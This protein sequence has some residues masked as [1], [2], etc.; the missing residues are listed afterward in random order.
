MGLAL[1]CSCNFSTMK[2]TSYDRLRV[3]VHSD[4]AAMGRAAALFAQR[5]I[6][7]AQAARGV[8]R[9]IFACAPSQDEFLD[10]LV[11]SQPPVDWS[12]VVVFHMDEYV[13]LAA[14]AAQ[15]FRRYLRSHLIGRIPKPAAFHPIGGEAASLD[16]ECARYSKL[17][18]EAP[19]DLVCLGIGENGHLAFNDP[20]VANFS[21]PALVKVVELDHTCRQQ[22][23]NDGC[24]PAIAAVPTHALTLTIPALFG[25]RV[26]CGVVPG[27]RKAQAVRDT[28]LGP[29]STACPAS[30]LRTHPDAVLHLDTASA[31]MLG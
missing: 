25:A 12:R 3:E 9:V 20:P 21:D 26:V 30:I 31:G 28:L 2:T 22:Q 8:A 24:F 27:S 5:T 6:A 1:C 7:A 16:A 13:G 11:A 15:S 4:R 18:G 29:V 23:V 17:L 19:V 14:D 10:A